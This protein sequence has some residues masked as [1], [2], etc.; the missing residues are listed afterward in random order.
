MFKVIWRKR[1]RKKLESL[2]PETKVVVSIGQ[3]GICSAQIGEECYRIVDYDISNVIRMIKYADPKKMDNY[4][5]NDGKWTKKE[6]HILVEEKE[7]SM[8]VSGLGYYQEEWMYELI[9]G[10]EKQE[11]EVDREFWGD[12]NPKKT[13]GRWKFTLHD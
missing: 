8:Y 11:A 9:H 13:Y 10:D 4:Y 2:F 5:F 3:K 6:S 1:I 7:G 12:I